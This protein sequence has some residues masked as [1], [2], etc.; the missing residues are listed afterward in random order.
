[1]R[2]NSGLGKSKN[3]LHD[4][5]LKE[6]EHERGRSGEAITGEKKIDAEPSRTKSRSDPS[7]R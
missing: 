4:P 3:N 5:T 2:S 1:M 7:S 6:H